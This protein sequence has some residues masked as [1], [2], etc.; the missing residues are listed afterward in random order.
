MIHG[1]LLGK[2]LG[3]VVTGT[4]GVAAYN[5][6]VWALKKAPAREI[7]VTMTAAGLK[8]VRKAEEGAEA[9]RLATADIV[10]EARERNGEDAPPPS[11]SVGHGHAH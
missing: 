10:A 2:A 7:A 8:G 6:V 5:G 9:V 1:A 11:Q 3:T 4:V